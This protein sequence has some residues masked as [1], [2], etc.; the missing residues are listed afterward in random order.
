MIHL[1]N[2]LT[3]RS[4]ATVCEPRWTNVFS[5][6][7]RVLIGLAA[8]GARPSAMLRVRAETQVSEA[9]E[10]ALQR[11]L[12]VDRIITRRKPN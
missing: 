12:N 2:F 10:E 1:L 9:H 3:Q 8:N 5:V 11:Q 4:W 7:R 6:L